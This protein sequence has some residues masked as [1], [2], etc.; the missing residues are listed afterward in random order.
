ME[1]LKTNPGEKRI[2]LT[3]TLRTLQVQFVNAL[4]VGS[5]TLPDVVEDDEIDW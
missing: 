2:Y 4:L 3:P 5:M 1:Y